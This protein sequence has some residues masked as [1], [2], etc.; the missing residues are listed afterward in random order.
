MK[1]INGYNLSSDYV[2]QEL[3]PR[4]IMELETAGVISSSTYVIF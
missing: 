4:V 2:G 1:K 3:Q